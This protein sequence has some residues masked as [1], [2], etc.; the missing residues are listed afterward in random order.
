MFSSKQDLTVA[1]AIALAGGPNRFANP[2]Q[3]V[4]VRRDKQGNVRRIPINYTEIVQGKNLQ[5]NLYLLAGD[6]VFIP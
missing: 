2:E 3:A 1:D 4:I 6:T 5:Q